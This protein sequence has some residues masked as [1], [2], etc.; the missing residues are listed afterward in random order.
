[1]SQARAA[2][3]V[4]A[5]IA[6]SQR[7]GANAQTVTMVAMGMMSQT[8][9]IFKSAGISDA[10]VFFRKTSVPD[11]PNMVD[12]MQNYVVFGTSNGIMESLI[13]SQWRK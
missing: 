12:Y 10:P 8:R 9:G 4:V 3:T 1:M 5:R 2:E 13:E 7:Y 11:G 6:P